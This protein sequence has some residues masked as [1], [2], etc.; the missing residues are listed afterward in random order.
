MKQTNTE[1]INIMTTSLT[2]D[3]QSYAEFMGLELD[4]VLENW[5]EIKESIEKEIED[6]F[7]HIPKV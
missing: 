6:I 4:Y 3:P 5:T 2:Y 1:T 7:G